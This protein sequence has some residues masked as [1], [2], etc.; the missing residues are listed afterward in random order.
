MRLSLRDS[1]G[2]EIDVK[3]AKPE[4]AVY[5]AMSLLSRQSSFDVGSLVVADDDNAPDLAAKDV[6]PIITAGNLIALAGRLEA[7]AI[8]LEDAQPGHAA[9]MRV[10]AKLC[11]HA[12]KVWVFT[13]VS[14]VA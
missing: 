8:M 4:D 10:A 6:P 13:S 14:L 7:R 1:K 2:V 11:R 9:D 12:V 3:T 5:T